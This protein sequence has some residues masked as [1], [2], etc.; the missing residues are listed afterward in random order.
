M[1]KVSKAEFWDYINTAPFDMSFT[2]ADYTLEFKTP[3]KVIG[4][5]RNDANKTPEYLLNN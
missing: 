4:I 2:C 5:L 3:E 1:Q